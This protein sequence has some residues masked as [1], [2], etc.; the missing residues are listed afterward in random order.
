MEDPE[1]ICSDYINANYVDGY[2]QKNAFISTQ[3][4]L[5]KTYGDFWRMVWEQQCVVVVMTTRCLER[6]RPKCGQY[7][8]LGEEEAAEYGHFEIINLTTEQ[9]SDYTISMLHLTNLKVPCRVPLYGENVSH[10]YS[11]L[12]PLFFC[13]LFIPFFIVWQTRETRS[14]AHMQFTSWPDYGVPLS[15]TAMLEFLQRMRDMQS[16]LVAAMGD[17]WIG[18]PLGPPIVV[19][20]SAGIGRTGTVFLYLVRERYRGL[21]IVNAL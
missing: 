18:H 8:P 10:S 14:V 12:T 13:F 3:G 6:G 21:I 9:Q 1:D 15:A 20:C 11:F 19:H 5:P 7:W 17:T 16:G 4:P 2:K